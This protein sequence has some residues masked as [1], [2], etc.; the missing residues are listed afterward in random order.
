MVDVGTLWD[1]GY[2]ESL[3]A[4]CALN[5]EVL[6]SLLPDPNSIF[7]NLVC[8]LQPAI[9]FKLIPILSNLIPALF[10]TN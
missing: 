5:L 9:G 4:S 6:E 8:L 2:T 7:K 10:E 3:S 1:A